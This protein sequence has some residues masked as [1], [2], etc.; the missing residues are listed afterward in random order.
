M[1]DQ[2]RASE[3]AERALDLW[4][5]GQLN[6]AVECLREAISLTEPSHHSLSEYHGSLAGLLSALGQD[7]EALAEYE[8]AL[9]I[10]ILE[11]GK[12]SSFAVAMG[13][14]F[15][16]EH[17]LKMCRLSEALACLTPSLSKAPGQEPLLRCVE[18]EALLRSGRRADAVRSAKLA[19]ANARSD[20][21]LTKLKERLRELLP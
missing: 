11:Y 3:L 2:K 18:A 19:I 16:A 20:D 7:D 14:Y 1:T 17:L 10:V 13:R 12:D 6:G 21:Q 8:T 4:E 5:N 15:L 9:R